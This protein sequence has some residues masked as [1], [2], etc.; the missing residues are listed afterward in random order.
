[1][2]YLKTSK[3]EKPHKEANLNKNKTSILKPSTYSSYSSGG[4]PSF[5]LNTLI[6][7]L[8][9]V[10]FSSK[11]TVELTLFKDAS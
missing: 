10:Y 9:G 2:L 11:V 6:V 8:L 1:M 7:P 3:Q 4:Y 5:T